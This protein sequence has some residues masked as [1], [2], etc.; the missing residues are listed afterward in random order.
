MTLRQQIARKS[1]LSSKNYMKNRII[2]GM[3]LVLPILL[4]A[5]G[6]SS[7]KADSQKPLTDPQKKALL[8]ETKLYF[9]SPVLLEGSDYVLYPLQLKRDDEEDYIMG[10]Y[11]RSGRD[12][13]WNIAF[14]N[15]GT[16]EYH[17]LDESRKF[18]IYSFGSTSPSG[19]SH[20]YQAGGSPQSIAHNDSLLYYSVVS[21]D[22]NKDG[23]LNPK[24]PTYLF[25]SDRAGRKFRQISP[26]GFD[27]TD[28]RSLPGTAKILL[29]G[30]K[31]DNADNRFN[32][33]DEAI[34]LVFDLRQK[35]FAGKIFDD[36]FTTKTKKLLN[37]QWPMVEQD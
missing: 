16:G 15:P 13:Y 8:E 7:R 17:L 36:D 23:A 20:G 9:N 11:G 2:L 21:L 27:V 6:D 4:L 31:D 37:Q 32:S 26:E 28:W 25:V 18:V 33:D 1:C 12:V 5:C 30:R 19:N 3:Y 34:P 29:T 22:Y 35:A 14:Y 10:S 24:D